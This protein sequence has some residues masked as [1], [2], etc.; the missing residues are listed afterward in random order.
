MNQEKVLGIVRHVLTLAAGYLMA[1]G[2]VDEGAANEIVA[3][4]MAIIGVIW[5]VK[6]KN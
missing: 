2:I 1:K 4:I 5:S 3:G 6:A